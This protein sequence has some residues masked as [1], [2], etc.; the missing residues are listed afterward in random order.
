MK[1][2]FNNQA[3]ADSSFAVEYGSSETDRTRVLM[4]GENGLIDLSKYNIPDNQ[5]CCARAYVQGGP[6]H[7]SG[8]NFTY[9]ATST[10]TVVYTLTGGV[11]NTSFSCANCD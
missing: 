11:D 7:D 10:V 4:A 9:E 8:D 1:V 2:Q 5:S 3:A 6:N